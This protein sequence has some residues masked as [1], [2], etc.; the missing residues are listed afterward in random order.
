MNS[1]ALVLVDFAKHLIP[2]LTET[3]LK[4]TITL[5]MQIE[6]LSICCE[7][8]IF[9]YEFV[10]CNQFLQIEKYRILLNFFDFLEKSRV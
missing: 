5:K 4:E 8:S 9:V 7:T 6:V 2:T 10:T 3:Y 1:I